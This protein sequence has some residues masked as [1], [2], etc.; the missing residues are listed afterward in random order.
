MRKAL[1][2]TVVAVVVLLGQ[3]AAWAALVAPTPANG[4]IV[5][6]TVSLKDDGANS[7]GINL[8]L[9]NCNGS[10]AI[11]VTNSANATVASVSVAG[12]GGASPG[13]A[14]TLTWITDN[15]PNGAYKITGTDTKKTSVCFGTSTSTTTSNVTVTNTGSLAYGGDTA[16][17]TGASATV[18]ATLTDQ[19]GVA[20][21]AGQ[22]VTFT[23]TGVGATTV[24]TTAPTVAGGVAQTTLPIGG[25][26]GARTLTVTSPATYYTAAST[27]VPF[28]VQADP[29]TTAVSSSQNPSTYGQGVSFT[30]AVSAAVGGT[31]TGTVQ[32]SVDGTNLGTPAALDGTGHATSPSTSTLTGGGHSVTAAYVHT[33]N[34]ANSSNG[35]TQTVNKAGTT[36]T[37]VSS[38]NP[39]DF[40]QP[41]T[42]TATVH[43]VGTGTGTPT[44][45]V[46]FQQNGQPIGGAV[47]L[48]P[49]G[50]AVSAPI[51][52]LGVAGSPYTITGTYQ[53]D[54]DFSASS[55]TVSQAVGKASTAIAV[56]S[57]ANPSVSGQ[58]VTFTATVSSLPPGAGTPSGTATF[59]VDGNPLGGAITLSGSGQATSSSIASLSPGDHTVSVAYGGSANFA[60]AT[61]TYVQHVNQAQT[62]TALTSSNDPSVFGQPVTFKAVV[63]VVA[64]GAGTPTGTVT[65][66]VDGT[67]LGSPVA[68]DGTGTA[69]SDAISS[70]VVGGHTVV[71]T[72]NGST[73]FATSAQTITQTVHKA[74]TSSTLTSSV[75]PSVYG[76]SVTFTAGVSV[77]APGAGSPTGTVS[78][79]D[80]ATLLAAVPLVPASGTGQATFSTAALTVGTHAVTAVYSGDGSFLGSTGATTQGVNK[81]SSATTVTQNG[82]TVQG[83]P[84]SFTASVAF[85]APGAGLP[86]GT[87]QFKLNGASQGA[88]VPL[89]GSATAVSAPISGLTP[90]SYLITAVYSGDGNLLPSSGSV[91]QAVQASGTTTS[92]VTTANPSAYGSAVTL[93]ATV[94]IP[95]PAVG[96]P[97]GTVDFYDGAVLLGTGDLS[98][99]RARRRPR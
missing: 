51:S 94:A 83:Q 29:T 6:G 40:G 84:V 60:T 32:F 12:S 95:P 76:Q 57:S 65:F 34:F 27:A 25:A 48:Q 4:S 82:P 33:G 37:V 70:L 55:V 9:T 20:P 24:S 14:A 50:T 28:T 23:L 63:A 31:P 59:T 90:G 17:V 74:A 85:V 36:T 10:T 54:A 46:T 61:T 45:T 42:F 99:V 30:A 91:G 93:T 77:T 96:T 15:V 16:K 7:G 1:A 11:A 2:F 47:M 56:G 69:T 64:P 97:S 3:T 71:A 98:P 73:D 66:T 35:L 5:S 81:A 67:P 18:K 38:A 53:G 68:L 75:S 43:K 72:Y 39:S 52:V 44:G 19:N 41:V 89:D 62:T 87:V 80:G 92:L 88:P 13:P 49:D 22:V 79:Y 58:A 86:T 8:L 26:P 21:A 78:F